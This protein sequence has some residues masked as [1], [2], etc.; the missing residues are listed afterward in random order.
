MNVSENGLKLIEDFEGYS[1]TAYFDSYGGV[2]TVGYGET[3]HVGPNTTMTRQQAE[4]DLKGLLEREYEP[5]IYGLGVPLNQNQYDALCS[6]VWNLGPGSLQWDVGRDLRARDYRGAADAMLQYD[7]AGGV[8][9]QGLRTRRERERALFLTPAG[10]SPTPLDALDPAERE[11]VDRYDALL[12]HPH[13]HAAERGRVWRE[14]VGLRK[15]VWRA[16]QGLG[17]WT[18]D[19]RAERYRIL[20]A[21]TS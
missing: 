6:F 8:V 3:E 14:L 16:A 19:H 2:W 20:K 7:A 11:A 21:R 12:R 10:P 15:Q 13:M 1:Y 17:G 9:L 4:V 5:A 18:A